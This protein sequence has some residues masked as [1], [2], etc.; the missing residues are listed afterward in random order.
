MKKKQ[1]EILKKKK[2]HL[3]IHTKK[4]SWG[5]QKRNI[6]SRGKIFVLSGEPYIWKTSQ[7]EIK[8]REAK[9]NKFKNLVKYDVVSGKKA[10]VSHK[11]LK[12]YGNRHSQPIQQTT[13][14]DFVNLDRGMDTQ[15]QAVRTIPVPSKHGLLPA[16][17]TQILCSYRKGENPK[18]IERKRSSYIWRKPN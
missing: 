4:Y 16:Y 9:R 1:P 17:H 10:F 6:S 18:K 3:S 14:E 8:R 15:E 13:D 7:I 11:W 2:K 5:H 12:K